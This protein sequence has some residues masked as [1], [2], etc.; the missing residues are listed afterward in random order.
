LAVILLA[1]FSGCRNAGERESG[2]TAEL[3]SSRE[4][5]GETTKEATEIEFGL[6]QSEIETRQPWLIG[7]S[8]LVACVFILLILL[9]VRKYGENRRLE[10]LVKKRTAE[11]EMQL[12]KLDLMVKATN[13][14]MWDMEV[15]QGD[16][17][18][19]DNIYTFSDKFRHLLGFEDENDFPNEYSFW[20][21]HLHPDDKYIAEAF[22]RHLLDASNQSFEAE[23]RMLKKDGEYAYFLDTSETIR[24]ERGRTVRAAGAIMDITER[25]KLLLDLEAERYIFQTMFDSVPDLIFCKDMDL[26]YTRCN[27]SLLKYFNLKKEDLIGKDDRDGL[28][29]PEKTAREFRETDRLVLNQKKV[30]TYEE[31]VPAPDGTSRLFETNKVPL[32]LDGKITGI[33]GIARDIT[34]RKTMEEEALNANKAKTMFLA[35][36]SHE[37]RTP[38][39]AII[40]TA[41][42]QLMR[43]TL[44]ADARAAL[45]RI[46]T[47]G[48]LLLGIINDILDLSRIEAGK[49]ELLEDKYEIASLVSDTAQLNMMRVGSKRIM[50]ELHI[51]ENMPAQMSGDELRVKQI[52]NNLLSNAFKYTSEGTVKLIVST[53]ESA[54]KDDKVILVISISDTGQ[55]MSEEQLDRLFDEYTRFNQE[56]NRATEGTGLGMSIIRNLISMMGGEITVESELGKGSTFTVRLPQNRVDSDVLGKEMAENLRLFRTSNKA[57]MR[58]T[59]IMREPMPYGKILIV[60][61]VETNAYVA[62]GLLAPYDLKIDSV[63]SG[64][65]AIEKIKDGKTYDVIFMDHMMPGMDGIEA[66]KRIRELGYDQPIVALTANAVAGQAGVFL[67]NGFD[68]FISKPIDLRQMNLLLNK[69]VRDKQPPEVIEAARKAAAERQEQLVLTR[70][71]DDPEFIRV[72][73][74]ETDKSLATL[75]D[76]TGKDGWHGNDEDIRVYIIHIH[77]IKNALANIGKMDLSGVALKLEQAAR[78][79][80]TEVVISET[81]DFF[82]ELRAYIEDLK[83]TAGAASGSRGSPVLDREI[84]G[85]DIAR[86]FEQAGWDEKAYVRILRSFAANVR[87]LLMSMEPVG[88]ENLVEYKKTVHAIKG[89]SYYVFAEKIGRQAEALEKAS[90]AGDFGYVCEHNPAFIETAWKLIGDLDEMLSAFRAENPKPVKPGPD[91]E[92]LSKILDACK[93]FNMD[94]LDDAMEEIERYQYESDDGLVD[95]LLE[96][97]NRMDM[98]EIVKKL[99]DIVS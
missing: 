45:E 35:N 82:Q 5:P 29:V 47:S 58:R 53:E 11:N 19:P 20:S 52:M 13:F 17:A 68:D 30:S 74:R 40:G 18:S 48:D 65:A 3:S 88:E 70:Q 76:L 97:V 90:G 92:T 63:S 55:G 8:I 14:G 46:Y 10:A 94:D 83:R 81:P 85:L 72:F 69:M 91:G 42:I 24:D 7:T 21:D 41:E 1:A 31:Y 67:R 37:I 32:F 43:E 80:I 33:M 99:S 27:E 38:M 61:D 71:A 12:L 64:Y 86:G 49:L 87:A 62:K 54:E 23:Y 78:N 73:I 95:W 77:T 51:D 75:E 25:K 4:M 44:D 79:R 15:T 6:E 89:T 56:T 22:D 59:Q 57:Q 26:N 84:D 16:P 39:N 9:F 50:F 2:G 28:G 96:A 34:E 36:M 60:D 66:T 98:T 93:R